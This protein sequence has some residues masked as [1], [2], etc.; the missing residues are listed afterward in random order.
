MGRTKGSKI[1]DLTYDKYFVIIFK[2]KYFTYILCKPKDKFEFLP[3]ESQNS[4][5]L[6]DLHIQRFESRFDGKEFLKVVPQMDMDG[7]EPDYEVIRNTM[8]PE[9]L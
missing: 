4:E 2:Y 6:D 3:L 5:T 7:D 1:K 8:I 9:L